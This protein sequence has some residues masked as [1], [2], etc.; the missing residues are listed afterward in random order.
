MLARFWSNHGDR[1]A[2]SCHSQR[3]T[4]RRSVGLERV[5]GAASTRMSQD[6]MV[7][8]LKLVMEAKAV[9]IDGRGMRRISQ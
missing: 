1:A 9:M 2:R 8:K 5:G 3:L 6:G 4:E 7:N